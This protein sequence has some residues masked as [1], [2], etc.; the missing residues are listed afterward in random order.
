MCCITLL[1]VFG[2]GVSGGLANSKEN[3][4]VAPEAHT[5]EFREYGCLLQSISYVFIY[6]LLTKINGAKYRLSDTN[7]GVTSC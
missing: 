4:F 6:D 2:I 5:K 3:Q 7:A 1:H